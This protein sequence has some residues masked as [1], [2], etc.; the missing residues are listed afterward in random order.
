MTVAELCDRAELGADARQSATPEISLRA[1]VEQLAAGGRLRDA[2]AALA[3][4]LPKKEAISW[5][6]ESVR[7]VPEAGGKPAAEPVLKAVEEWVAGA[8]EQKRQTAMSAAEQAGVATAA[9]CLGL[10]VFLS[11]GSIAPPGTPVAP[12]PEPHLCGKMMAAALAL[13]VA[14]DPQHEADLYR[15]FV[16]RGFKMAADLKVW[17]EQ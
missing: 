12:E 16:D 2:A 14:V 9:G 17:E 15:A 5:G 7:K 11:G 1:Y 6:L 13:A 10:A 3:Q 4:L 8:D